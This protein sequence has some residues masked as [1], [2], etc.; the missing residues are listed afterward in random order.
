M[1][2]LKR[3]FVKAYPKSL[4]ICVICHARNVPLPTG[5]QA[6]PLELFSIPNMSSER[7][8]LLTWKDS[9]T[10]LEWQCEFP[11]E[12]TWYEAQEY[13]ESL[14]LDGKR[15]WRFPSLAELESLLDRS[16][17]RADGRPPM[18]PA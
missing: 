14:S 1:V 7:Y 5:R 17:A 3:N 6:R 2:T 18:R 9:K 13:A 8:E 12:M 10:G 16:K 4:K 15:D 11:G